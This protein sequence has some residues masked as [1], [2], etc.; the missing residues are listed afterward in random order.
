MPTEAPPQSSGI[1]SRQA[2]AYLRT[3]VLTASP[4]KLRLLLLEGVLRFL[5]QGRDGLERK[6]YAASYEGFSQARNIVVELMTSIREEQAP[7]LCARVRSLYTFIFRI[8]AEASLEKDPAKAD[9]AI[10]LMEYERATW[11]LAMKR[12]ASESSDGSLTPSGPID[13]AGAPPGRAALSVQG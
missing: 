2:N 1:P 11:E 4:E 5:R 8:I 9:K 13:A 6:D 3:Q 12:I 7:E 10:E